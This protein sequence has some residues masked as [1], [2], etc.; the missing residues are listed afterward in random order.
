MNKNST[1]PEIF[2]ISDHVVVSRMDIH[3]EFQYVTGTRTFEN[4]GLE[5]IGVDVVAVV[6]VGANG[7]F[8]GL[9]VCL[10]LGLSVCRSSDRLVTFGNW[11]CFD[12]CFCLFNVIFS[13]FRC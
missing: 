7:F 1:D 11:V 12:V 5:W 4:Y 3:I 2:D 13:A 8:V 10:S 6:V 9:I